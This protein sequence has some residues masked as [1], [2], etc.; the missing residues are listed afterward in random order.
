MTLLGNYQ[1]VTEIVLEPRIDTGPIPLTAMQCMP[2]QFLQEG[3]LCARTLPFALRICGSLDIEALKVSLRT[4]LDR[5]ESLRMR[6]SSIDGVI[7]QHAV[8]PDEYYLKTV[9]ITEEFKFGGEGLAR[10]HIQA[11]VD[12]K[13]SQSCDPLFEA[14]L[15]KLSDDEHI[16]AISIDH[17]ITDGVSNEILRRELWILYKQTVDGLFTSLPKMSLQFA[18][19]AAWLQKIYPIWIRTHGMYWRERLASAGR[20]RWPAECAGVEQRPARFSSLDIPF[21]AHLTAELRSFARRERTVPA[22]VMLS[23]YLAVVARLCGQTDLTLA[24][25][26]HGRHRIE[27]SRMIGLLATH[28]H[29]R[30][31]V[32][33]AQ[34]FL[35]L[36]SHAARELNSASQH[37]DFDWAPSLV[38]E[39]KPALNFHWQPT[40]STGAMSL[41]NDPSRTHNSIRIKLYPIEPCM[42][43][44]PDFVECLPYDLMLLVSSTAAQLTATVVYRDNLFSLS[45]VERFARNLR[46]FSEFFIHRPLACVGS[47]SMD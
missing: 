41:F 34:S 26:E 10:T 27:L 43:V 5:H 11:F 1:S 21:G 16:L 32:T 30:L 7:S 14:K 42:E 20:I 33:K 36:V 38:P 45:T 46:L 25:V 37:R 44:L 24:F 4:I 40:M 19:Y 23:L 6:I 35:D 22:V 28:L 47:V 12:H 9:D 13:V 17:L 29:L 18:D 31:Q 15:F 3:K 8:A 39:F 2:W